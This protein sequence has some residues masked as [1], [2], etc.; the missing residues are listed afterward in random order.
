MRTQRRKQLVLL[1]EDQRQLPIGNDVSESW[2]G[3][4]PVEKGDKEYTVN[5]NKLVYREVRTAEYSSQHGHRVPM[6]NS[7]REDRQI[8]WSKT[9]GAL[10]TKLWSSDLDL[11]AMW[12]RRWFGYTEV[13]KLSGKDGLEA[14]RSFRRHNNPANQWGSEFWIPN[15]C[16]QTKQNTSTSGKHPLCS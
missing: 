11:S 3:A 7:G 10:N 2:L 15:N 13:T 14:V 8:E 4:G 9:W 5:R 6:G 1:W 12:G 16:F